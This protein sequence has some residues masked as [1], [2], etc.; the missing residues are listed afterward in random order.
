MSKRL[1]LVLPIVIIAVILGMLFFKRPANESPKSVET[2]TQE[3][4]VT[5]EKTP[6][7]PPDEF[8]D[9]LDEA[10]IELEIIDAE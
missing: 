5:E 4:V 6:E 3:S 9:Q 10:F 1:L 2:P 7:P 8:S